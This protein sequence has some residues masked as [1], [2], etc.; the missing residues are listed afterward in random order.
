M[1]EK[2]IL[3]ATSYQLTAGIWRA[4]KLHSYQVYQN[5]EQGHTDF[6]QFLQQHSKTNV[7]LLADAV[8]EDY[9]LESLPHT[10]GG[11][12]RELVER[13]LSQL[14]R[15][16]VYRAAHFIHREKDKRKD[17]LFLLISLNNAEFMQGWVACIEAQQAPLAGVY[18][19][20]MMSEVLVQRLKLKATH[21]LLSER[22]NSGLRQTYLHNGRLR[23]SRLAPIPSDMLNRLGYFYLTE[24]EKT[25][26]YLISQRFV[27]RDTA[28]HMVLPALNESS[29]QICRAIEQEHGIICESVNLA[30]VAQDFKLDVKQLELNPEL[31]HMHLLASGSAP[32]NIAPASLVKHHKINALRK[33]INVATAFV[34]LAGLVLSTLYLKQS[35]DDA[36]ELKQTITDTRMQEHRYNEVAK[37]FPTTPIPSAELQVAAELNEAISKYSKAPK[38]M[39]QVVSRALD[40]TPDIQVNRLLWMQTNNVNIQDEDRAQVT[41]S[42]SSTPAASTISAFVPDPAVLYK[43]GFVSGEIKRF[44]GDYRA[45]L[46]L[47]SRFADTLKADPEVQFVEVVQAPVNVS[48]YSNLQGSTTDEKTALTTAALFKLK[49]ILKPQGQPI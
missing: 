48:S 31:L 24:T 12:R 20:P 35:V 41:P 16:V 25:R 39:M 3:C 28:L 11:A 9:R 8:E 27:T 46:N 14:Y 44:S 13:K 19:L 6:T 15:G 29:R 37:N 33:S 43:V 22:L 18:L 45:A 5:D 40:K 21:L 38:R 10:F 36:A 17:D 7:Y 2:I 4:G 42:V 26:L 23:I 49:V 32:D 1:F 34:V 47:V 30:E